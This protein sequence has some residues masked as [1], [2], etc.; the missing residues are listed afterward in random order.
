M[1]I[2]F[3]P[4]L[5]EIPDPDRNLAVVSDDILDGGLS[6]VHQPVGDPLGQGLHCLTLLLD[7]KVEDNRLNCDTLKFILIII[8]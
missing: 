1:N 8:F 4:H 7:S 2:I 3:V 6:A 5:V